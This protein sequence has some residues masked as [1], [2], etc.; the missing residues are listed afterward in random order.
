MAELGLIVPPI[1]HATT[2]G[3]SL[4]SISPISV[5]GPMMHIYLMAF[6]LTNVLVEECYLFILNPTKQLVPK[7]SLTQW[8]NQSFDVL[9]RRKD[10][11][12]VATGINYGVIV[13]LV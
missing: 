7:K 2:T 12:D 13:E 10:D 8:T 11:S 5:Q 9:G 1:V 3:D 6:L 4:S